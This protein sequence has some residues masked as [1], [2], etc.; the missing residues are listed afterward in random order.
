MN[1]N[2]KSYKQQE[3][4]ALYVQDEDLMMYE[5]GTDDNNI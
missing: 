4:E 1:L 5:V 2:D 3:G